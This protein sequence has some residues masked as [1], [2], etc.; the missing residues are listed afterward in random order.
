MKR[1][2][3][4]VQMENVTNIL[5]IRYVIR[6]F[7]LD[8]M[9]S[10]SRYVYELFPDGKV[11]YGHYEKGTRKPEEMRET[12]QATKDDYQKL[13][14]ELNACV[15]SA[16]RQNWYVD[17][18]TAK[19]KIYHAFGHVETMDRGY[20]NEGTDVGQLITEYIFTTASMSRW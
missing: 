2:G 19:V 6:T 14:A 18:C 11:T 15:A 13:C 12:H 5:K 16:D 8:V 7:D 9:C 1:M 10:H 17:D 20:G 4:Y 3:E